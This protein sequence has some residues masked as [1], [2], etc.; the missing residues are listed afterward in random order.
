MNSE[1]VKAEKKKKREIYEEYLETYDLENIISEMTNSVVHSQDP[2]PIVYMIK[3]L[4]GLLTEDERTEFNIN[5]EPPYPKGVPI[6]KFPKYKIDNILSKYLTKNNWYNYKYRKTCYNNDINKLTYLSD[7]SNEDKIGIVLVD[8][9]CINTYHD[10]LDN[11]IYESHKLEMEKSISNN[12]YKISDSPRLYKDKL[13]FYDELKKSL[14]TLKFIFYRNI[15]GYT[16]NNIDKRNGKLKNIIEE[17]MKRMKCVDILPDDLKLIETSK[18]E[19]FIKN[20]ET[21][22]SE[23]IWMINAGFVNKNYT[24]HERSIWV[25]EKKSLIILINFS[26]HFE[27]ILS[28]NFENFDEV[29]YNFNYVMEILK[30]AK[31][32]FTFDTDPKYGYITSNLSYLGRG[33]KLM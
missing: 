16:Y 1:N 5:I 13:F 19:E 26:N 29:V 31:V 4:T 30:Q 12:L 28:S 22:N 10:L 8:K 24:I 27:L 14:K 15:E 23:Y 21:I 32:R 17:E 25:S 20:D 7:H 18:M 6:V 33:F 2:N 11:I 3:Y 9:D